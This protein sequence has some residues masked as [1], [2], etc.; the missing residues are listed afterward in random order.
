[1]PSSDAR[2]SRRYDLTY[3]SA[4]AER[5]EL[6]PK[7]G[8][9]SLTI[10]NPSDGTR[11]TV[12]GEE[13]RRAAWSEP[14]PVIA[15]TTAVVVTTPG[16]AG[17]TRSVTLGAGAS[18][19]LTVDAQSGAVDAPAVATA[20]DPPPLEVPHRRVP[21]RTWAYV[22]GGLGAVGVATFAV[23]GALARADYDDLQTACGA[24]PCPPSRA[25]EIAS[26]KTKQTVANVGLAIGIAGVAA[27]ATL[28]V[29]SLDRHTASSPSAAVI[30]APAWL[31]V[32]GTL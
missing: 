9:V 20:P 28:F 2:R 27:G 10:E 7:I 14:A 23:F 13:I 30:V 32:G 5:A 25:D 18:T 22:A 8:F 21:L 31:G 15:G 17:V 12:G 3:D 1:M 24:G 19:S 29:V 16:H 26:G 4:T 11:V 6:Q